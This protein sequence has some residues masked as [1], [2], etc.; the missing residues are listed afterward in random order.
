MLIKRCAH[1]QI[2]WK[3]P[4][5]RYF[6]S[7]Q[8][9]SILGVELDWPLFAY[10]CVI[11][12]SDVDRSHAVIHCTLSCRRLTVFL[13]VRYRR[14]PI[15]W[16]VKNPN[17]GFQ[18]ELPKREDRAVTTTLRRHS[19][20]MMKNK[21]TLTFFGYHSITMEEYKDKCKRIVTRNGKTLEINLK[22]TI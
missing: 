19:W 20:Q 5:I 14:T 12:E 11:R 15:S 7:L 1:K 21:S 2:Y 10:L 16:K 9:M 18:P 3:N 6:N 8:L 13:H 17:P 4:I 22:T